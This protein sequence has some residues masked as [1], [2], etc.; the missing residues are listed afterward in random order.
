MSIYSTISKSQGNTTVQKDYS[1]KSSAQN[2]LAEIFS[3]D[4]DKKKHL[5][6]KNQQPSLTVTK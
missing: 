3:D 4:E 6:L 5:S 1:F 2:D